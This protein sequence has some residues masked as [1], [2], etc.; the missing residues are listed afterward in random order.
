[1]IFI[2]AMRIDQTV[3]ELEQIRPMFIVPCHDTGWKATKII[4][5]SMPKNF[6]LRAWNNLRILMPSKYE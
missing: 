5:N 1:M 6:P 4:L 3:E 2:E